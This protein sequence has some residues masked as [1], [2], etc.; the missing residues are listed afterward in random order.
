ML[1]LNYHEK[2]TNSNYLAKLVEITRK[3]ES[4]DAYSSVYGGGFNW[5]LKQ[6]Q[7]D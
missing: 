2:F 3:R 5:S 6:S 1:D 4:I 7:K